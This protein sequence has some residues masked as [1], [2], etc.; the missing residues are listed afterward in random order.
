MRS[1]G[2]RT[3]M[4]LCAI[5]LLAGCTLTKITAT[6]YVIIGPPTPTAT[7]TFEPLAFAPTE[8]ATATPMPL[9]DPL[10]QQQANLTLYQKD[11]HLCLLP[12]GGAPQYVAEAAGV[13]YATISS[14]GQLIATVHSAVQDGDTF[15]MKGA[16]PFE[17]HIVGP[18]G[19]NDH[20]L[21]ASKDLGVTAPA[22]MSRAEVGT[23]RLRLDDLEW[24]PG[25][26]RI[27]FSADY[28]S[29][30]GDTY[31][32]HILNA[33]TGEHHILLDTGSGG[34]FLISP[35]GHSV[36]VI[37]PGSI[38]MMNSDGSGWR[39][40]VLPYKL[41]SGSGAPAFVRP[42]WAVDSSGLW[43][44][45]PPPDPNSLE[46]VIQ[47]W[48]IP[49]DGSHVTQVSSVNGLR[50]AFAT[51][52][53]AAVASPDGQYLA[54]VTT[55]ADRMA[56]EVRI[57]RA[58]GSGNTLIYTGVAVFDHWEADSRHF[59]FRVGLPLPT[60]WYRGEV[61]GSYQLLAAPAAPAQGCAPG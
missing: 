23:A 26:H 51:A 14:D 45:L 19:Q 48:S 54:A 38:G 21:L 37:T 44:A 17:I 20:L 41:N 11:G 36:A 50:V 29:V 18:S 10:W 28:A 32:L 22:S 60:A 15:L 52:G 58:D 61:G 30:T 24:A 42:T 34:T 33:D 31:S 57:L 8:L 9:P 13:S 46:Q 40:D 53:G 27:I 43:V 3:I 12:N 56:N 6:P 5:P 25:T 16:S 35:D 49:A 55:T 7:P 59:V 47:T 2:W 39:R 4:T 1:P